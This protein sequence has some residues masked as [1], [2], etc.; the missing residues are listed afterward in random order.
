[1]DLSRSHACPDCGQ[2]RIVRPIPQAGRPP[3]VVEVWWCEGCGVYARA[4]YQATCDGWWHEGGRCFCATP[5]GWDAAVDASVQ[6]ANE[7]LSDR[8]ARPFAHTRVEGSPAEACDAGVHTD[9]CPPAHFDP[10]VP[11][12]W[13]RTMPPVEWSR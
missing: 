12:E 10:P 13:D 3:F 8:G 1:M 5:P 7:S 6:Q 4:H 2:P 9:A 11:L